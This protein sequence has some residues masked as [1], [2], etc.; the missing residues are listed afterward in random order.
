[1]PG[2]SE[3]T[4]CID[5]EEMGAR[6]YLRQIEAGDRALHLYLKDDKEWWLAHNPDSVPDGAYNGPWRLWTTYPSGPWELTF[7]TRELA[8]FHLD[9]LYYVDY[10]GDEAHSIHEAKTVPLSD[11]PAFVQAEFE[12]VGAHV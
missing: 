8:E 12:E 5:P 1:M 10:Y 7:C 2:Q 3:Q 9:E 11:A 6:D 4:S